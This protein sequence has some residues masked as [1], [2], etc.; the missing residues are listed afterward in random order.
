MNFEERLAEISSKA[1]S[2]ESRKALSQG[3]D[4]GRR[5]RDR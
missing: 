1:H 5:A 3:A 2:I 4:S